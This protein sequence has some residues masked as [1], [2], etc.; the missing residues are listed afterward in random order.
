M[1]EKKSDS[2]LFA[3]LA[4]AEL[5]L[6][7]VERARSSLRR[8]LPKRFYT[9]VAV[10]PDGT[11]Y[12]LAIDGKPVL[13]P[14]RKPLVVGTL[15]F[16]CAIEAEWAA[17]TDTIDPARMPAT[18][19]AFAALDGV[20]SEAEAV[21]AEIARFAM[22]DL[23]LYRADSPERLIARERK[24]WDPVVHWAEAKFGVALKLG[25]GVVHVAQDPRLAERVT[26]ALPA[27][28][29]RLAALHVLTTLTGSALIA[30]MVGD[31][32][33]PPADGWTAAH[34]DEDWNAEL[35]GMDAEAADRRA[36]RRSDY[37]AALEALDR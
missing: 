3:E 15:R 11:D 16:A 12:R 36:F 7:P 28:P 13:T 31:G 35:W 34:L 21:K 6:D 32:Q 37:D 2:D 18:R 25:T 22:S 14:A 9:D 29:F 33:L 17:Q 19:L 27:D 1:T 23:V 4:S 26:A 24:L 20:S 8:V 10:V 30:L 5:A